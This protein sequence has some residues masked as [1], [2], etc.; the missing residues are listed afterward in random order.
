MMALKRDEKTND[1]RAALGKVLFVQISSPL[2][3]LIC[4]QLDGSFKIWLLFLYLT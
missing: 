3:C 1:R 4:M 2:L